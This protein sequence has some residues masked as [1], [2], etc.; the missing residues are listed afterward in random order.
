M[1]GIDWQNLVTIG[2][3]AIAGGYLAIRMWPRRATK[4]G[5]CGGGCSTCPSSA[6]Q[7][8]N[9]SASEPRVVSLEELARPPQRAAR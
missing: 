7:N 1:P 2:L 9:G 4:S 5:G 3:V 6:P 8:A